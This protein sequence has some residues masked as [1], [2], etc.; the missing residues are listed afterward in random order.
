MS[1]SLRARGPFD[2]AQSKAWLEGWAPGGVRGTP[3]DHLHLALTVEGGWEPVAVCLQGSGE[4][5][6]VETSDGAPE[7]L[8]AQIERMLSL[9]VDG[10]QWPEV[11]R[12]D[13]VI[14][15]LQEAYPGLRPVC[16]PS[17]YEAA[18][19]AILSQRRRMTQAAGA[20][21]RLAEEL[22][23]AIEMH[24]EILHAFPAPARLLEL[25]SFRGIPTPKVE[26]LNL[27]AG[28]A[29]D[30]L[31]DGAR[32]RAA[33]SEKGIEELK[34]IPGIGDFS[35]E[36]IVVRGA[37]APDVFPTRE[38]RLLATMTDLYGL[39]ADSPLPTL[40]R[41]AEQWRPFRSWAAVLIRTAAERQ[42][43]RGP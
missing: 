28:A 4:G 9:D 40:E 19:W 1:F 43:L 15:N 5:V 16:F 42:R 29:L 23:M 27:V 32:L 24:G 33:P 38:R 39:E 22:G 3:G 18:V 35:A 31:L 26:R 11:S 13:P 6:L 30:G 41:I 14:R 8:Q 37:G 25:R 2:L 12:R 20:K 7:G 34:R 17:P 36:L 10:S 21:Q